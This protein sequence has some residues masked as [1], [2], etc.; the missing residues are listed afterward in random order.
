MQPLRPQKSL[1][2]MYLEASHA[3]I[4]LATRCEYAQEDAKD[5]TDKNTARDMSVRCKRFADKAQK[6]ANK[7]LLFRDEGSL[8]VYAERFD[9]VFKQF[10]EFAVEAESVL[11]EIESKVQQS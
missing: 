7:I 2:E 3:A 4:T 6:A 1:T 8:K 11:T 5:P 10:V 9:A